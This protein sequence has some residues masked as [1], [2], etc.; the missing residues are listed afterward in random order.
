MI[1]NSARHDN[2]RAVWEI[3][4]RQK[5][6]RDLSSAFLTGKYRVWLLDI[7]C[8]SLL[9]AKLQTRYWSSAVRWRI[10]LSFLRCTCK[11]TDIQI[12]RI[13]SCLLHVLFACTLI[14]TH[15]DTAL[16]NPIDAPRSLKSR[17]PHLP[18]PLFQGLI[19]LF[20]DVSI[21][22]RIILSPNLIYQQL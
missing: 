22:L 7:I 12:T 10:L 1:I 15:L 16:L 5:H 17:L 11:H 13:H 18:P 6:G 4:G 3:V 20:R 8:L 2:R 14:L 19:S 21:P 9:T